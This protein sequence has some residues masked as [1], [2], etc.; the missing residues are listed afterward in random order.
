[1]GLLAGG[2]LVREL[3][4]DVRRR[5]AFDRGDDLNAAAGGEDVL[6]ADDSFD[7]VVTTFDED[8]GLNLADE[9]EGRV[10]GEEYHRV[11]GGESGHD[12]GALALADDGARGAFEA[13]DRGVGVEA[14]DELRAKPAAVLKQGDVA[15]M[16]EVEAAV[17]EDDGLA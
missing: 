1:M 16:Q 4:D 15:D 14:E 11:D 2:F 12:A 6:V 8:V 10:L 7:R 13:L 9:L 3:T 5:E 17:G